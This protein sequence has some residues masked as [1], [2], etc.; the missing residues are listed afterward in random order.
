MATRRVSKTE[1]DETPRRQATTP[2]GRE[3]QL[4]SMAHD[5]AEKRIREGTASAQEIVHFLRLGSSREWLEQQRLA[6]ENALLEAKTAAIASQQRVE[7]L[8]KEALN[9]MRAY[10]GQPPLDH[11]DEYED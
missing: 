2:Q 11:G 6:H 7:E 3:N 10:S 5:L 4:I 1:P 9:S 8:Y